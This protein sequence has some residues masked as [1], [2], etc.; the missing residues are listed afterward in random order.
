M[1]SLDDNDST[2]S[3]IVYQLHFV[4]IPHP[5]ADRRVAAIDPL[6]RTAMPAW[7]AAPTFVFISAFFFTCAKQFGRPPSEM[8]FHFDF[9]FTLRVRP[10]L[11]KCVRCLSRNIDVCVCVC[12]CCVQTIYR[13]LR[14]WW[15]GHRTYICA[16]SSM[17]FFLGV[18]IVILRLSALSWGLRPLIW[19]FLLVRIWDFVLWSTVSARE[20]LDVGGLVRTFCSALHLWF[21]TRGFL[22]GQILRAKPLLYVR[23]CCGLVRTTLHYRKRN[24][25]PLLTIYIYCYLLVWLMLH[26]LSCNVRYYT[27]YLAGHP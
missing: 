21:D 9:S 27:L 8:L 7:Q 13:C 18:C 16:D 5:Q 3:A 10:A 12:V 19:T 15:L 20:M 23:A 24:F 22:R 2:S 6:R 4:N 11:V 17:N 26:V 14:A 1:Q 25:L